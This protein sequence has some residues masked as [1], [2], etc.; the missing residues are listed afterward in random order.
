MIQTLTLNNAQCQNWVGCTVR[1]PRTQAA[2]ALCVGRTHAA[3]WAPC[4]DTKIVLRYKLMPCALCRR[5]HACAVPSCRR[6]LGRVT[7]AVASCCSATVLP[8][9][10]QLPCTFFFLFFFSF[11]FVSSLFHLLEDHKILLLFFSNLP[12]EPKKNYYNLFFYF[13]IFFPVLHTVK[14]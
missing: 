8:S 3:R 10:H 14:P 2:R 1:T 13:F 6:A 7:H 12:I 11:I 5:A 4:R 9:T